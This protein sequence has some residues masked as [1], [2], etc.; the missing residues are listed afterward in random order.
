MKLNQI[1]HEKQRMLD[2]EQKQLKSRL[3]LPPVERWRVELLDAFNFIANSMSPPVIE[4][5]Q[6]V[7]GG[8]LG[9][10]KV[11]MGRVGFRKLVV[12][13]GLFGAKE[14]V[15][16]LDE[17]FK[18]IDPLW[19]EKINKTVL[20]MILLHVFAAPAW[21]PSSLCGSGFC[22]ARRYEISI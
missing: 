20:G 21:C 4:D 7:H 9:N 10:K 16:A 5:R 8:K 12:H 1:K 17:Y 13:G 18:T 11:L 6:A 15:Q 19:Y 14:E 3:T 22:A 2:L